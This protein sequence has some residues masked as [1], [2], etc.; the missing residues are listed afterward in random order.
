MHFHRLLVYLAVLSIPAFAAP[1][2]ITF[3]GHGS[4]SLNGVVF[5]DEAFTITE[6]ADTANIVQIGLGVFYLDSSSASINIEGVGDFSFISGTRTWYGG[7]VVG[8]SRSGAD[9]VNLFNSYG[10]LPPSDSPL[11]GWN[12]QTTIGPLVS[13]GQLYQWSFLPVNTSGGP[14]FFNDG[15]SE[16]I[17]QATVE[18]SNVPEPT[19]LS[20]AVSGLAFVSLLSKFRAPR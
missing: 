2:T 3:Q 4:G 15:D 20:L 18:T 11:F 16:M 8:F 5:G 13:L 1:I 17:F 12:I 14:L 7:S 9:G 19:S 6:N 10:T